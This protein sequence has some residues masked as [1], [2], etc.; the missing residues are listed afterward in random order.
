MNQVV[1]YVYF[2]SVLLQD[3]RVSA[4]Q[5]IEANL[6]EIKFILQV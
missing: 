6:A 4:W 3:S 5:L 2:S 1:F